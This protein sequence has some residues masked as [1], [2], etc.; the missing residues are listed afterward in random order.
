MS[1]AVLVSD[2]TYQSLVAQAQ[3]LNQ[4][5]DALAEQFLREHMAEQV[6]KEHWR[7]EMCALVASIHA[8][9]PNAYSAAER[10]A[11]ITA[12]RAE[13]KELHRARRRAS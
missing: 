3:K 1:I 8:D 7:D 10:E 6:R 13:V 9:L 4:S 12:A 2:T 11:D 5:P